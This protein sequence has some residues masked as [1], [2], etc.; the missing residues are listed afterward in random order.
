MPKVLAIDPGQPSK[1]CTKCG[2]DLPLESFTR[3]SAGKY[4]RSAMCRTCARVRY[5]LP[6]RAEIMARGR[7]RRATAEGR[8]KEK[9]WR[10]AYRRKHRLKRLV[11]EAKVRAR[12]HGLPFDLD[13]A[14]LSIPDT[15]PVLGIRISCE[16]S[17]RS[18]HSP[19]IERI[20][21]SQGYVRGNVIVVSWRAN[22]LKSDA[23]LSE[24]RRI[25]RFYEAQEQR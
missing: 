23:T 8:A 10:N 7:V 19:S 16:S 20:D 12:A 21:N 18:E 2:L 5:Y 9:A 1:V 3:S 22:R 11:A 13:V 25:V 6:R 17:T 15:C 14:T 24:L 4:G